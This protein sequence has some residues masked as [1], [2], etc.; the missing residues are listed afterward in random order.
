MSWLTDWVGGKLQKPA[1]P[2]P[3]KGLFFRYKE[4]VYVTNRGGW[5][6]HYEITP[7]KRMS[8]PGCSNCGSMLDYLRELPE[9]LE[10]GNGIGVGGIV[11]M[12]WVSDGPAHYEHG[13][14]ESHIKIVP[15]HSNDPAVVPHPRTP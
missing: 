4:S 3:C 10:I 12:I 15:H 14:D 7:L 8:C 13:E 9:E 1:D 6:Q 11:E 2:P 5:A